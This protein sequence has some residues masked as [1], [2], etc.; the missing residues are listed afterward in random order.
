MFYFSHFWPKN[1]IIRTDSSPDT[2]EGTVQCR[3]LRDEG[4]R[5]LYCLQN[6]LFWYEEG[7]CS[8][9][10]KDEMRSTYQIY[11]CGI[12]SRKY[13]TW[14]RP[15]PKWEDNINM[16]LKDWYVGVSSGVSW[17]WREFKDGI[18]IFFL[19]KWAII[20]NWRRTQVGLPSLC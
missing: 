2:E 13:S 14:E 1:W 11:F 19:T 5:N 4:F 10:D 18:R 16:N 20:R 12:L 6:I 8:R 9:R 3:M 7:Q 15:T 17:F